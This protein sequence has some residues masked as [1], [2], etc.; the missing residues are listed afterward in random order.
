MNKDSLTQKLTAAAYAL[1]IFAIIYVIFWIFAKIKLVVILLSVSI[2]LAYV[3]IPLVNF[4]CSP[5]VFR[6]KNKKDGIVKEIFFLKKGFNRILSISI[7]YVIM[8][9]ILGIIISYVIPNVNREFKN[10]VKNFPML[11]NEARNTFQNYSEK[12]TPL[13]PEEARSYTSKIGTVLT[14][15]LKSLGTSMIQKSIPAVTKVFATIVSIFIIPIITFY[16]LMDIDK[17][18]RGFI[19][20][21]PPAR[22]KEIMGLLHEIDLVL[23]RYIRGQ[24]IVCLVIGAS[25]TLALFLWRVDYYFLIGAFSGIIDII[26]YVGVIISLI[27]AFLLGLIKHQSIW[28]AIGIV[29][30]LELIHYLEGHIIVPAVV[31][32]S[33]GLPPLVVIISLIIGAELM[34]IMGMFLA[35]P[36]AAIVRVTINYYIR[37]ITEARE[38]GEELDSR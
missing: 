16:I 17:Y 14:D 3:L 38:T 1:G 28:I 37:L 27:P 8:F 33:V 4:F 11:V 15:E 12:L 6:I 5:I 32:Q 22:R 30:T 2:L 35:I 36:V 7:V 25:I 13:I 31:G 18:R 23:G 29:A 10:L 9:L 26:P 24:L 21:I 19:A 34:G 20:I